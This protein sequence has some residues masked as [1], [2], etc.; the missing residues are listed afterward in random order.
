MGLVQWQVGSWQ[1]LGV[2]ENR[3]TWERPSAPISWVALFHPLHLHLSSSSSPT[4]LSCLIRHPAIN[5][6]I[7]PSAIALQPEYFMSDSVLQQA[8][9]S[10]LDNPISAVHPPAIAIPGGKEEG[11]SGHFLTSVALAA[12]AVLTCTCPGFRIS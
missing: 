9:Q 4:C 5:R 7:L 6:S 3:L 10:T 12:S 8:P 11:L 2:R 1:Q